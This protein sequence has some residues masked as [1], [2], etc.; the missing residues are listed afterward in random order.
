MRRGLSF[1]TV[2]ARKGFWPGPS[3]AIEVLVRFTSASRSASPQLLHSASPTPVVGAADRHL[4]RAPSGASEQD[5]FHPSHVGEPTVNR[6]P[7]S[8]HRTTRAARRSCSKNRRPTSTHTC[9][10]TAVIDN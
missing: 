9:A 7:G 1:R 2:R 5:A 3:G 6:K 4:V 10:S 8:F